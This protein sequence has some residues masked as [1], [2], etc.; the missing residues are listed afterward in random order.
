MQS[1][2]DLCLRM[3]FSGH[4][5]SSIQLGSVKTSIVS[6]LFSCCRITWFMKRWPGLMTKHPL[7]DYTGSQAS[8][9]KPDMSG[10]KKIRRVDNIVCMQKVIAGRN[11][12]VEWQT[13]RIHKLLVLVTESCQTFK[14]LAKWC[15]KR[16]RQSD[17]QRFWMLW[18]QCPRGHCWKDWISRTIHTMLKFSHCSHPLQ[19]NK[20]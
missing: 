8:S 6:V 10:N 11:A 3:S 7:K 9:Q 15:F 16:H 12:T 18:W 1:S 2:I 5:F 14:K 17:V 13:W 20:T 4:W 19:N